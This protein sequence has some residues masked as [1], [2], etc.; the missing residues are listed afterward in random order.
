MPEVLRESLGRG[1]L[2]VRIC[3]SEEYVTSKLLDLLSSCSEAIAVGDFVCAKLVSSGYVPKVCV[4][5]GVTRRV[6][7]QSVSD[8]YF[9]KVVRCVNPRSHVCIDAIEKIL[10]VTRVLK[11]GENAL[12]L[13]DGEEDLL[14]LPAI[15]RVSLGWC[16]IYGLP[17]CGVELVVV[18]QDIAETAR[19][20]LSLFEEVE[21]QL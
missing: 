5:D 19:R 14:A 18:D 1:F 9:S 15:A 7:A 12:V 13:V 11:P 6:L 16:V 4:V 21:L 3:G 8:K 10:E 20:I 17:G 2:G